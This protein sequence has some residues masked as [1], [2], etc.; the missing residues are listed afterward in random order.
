M[1]AVDACRDCQVW[2]AAQAVLEVCDLCLALH[3]KGVRDMG[4]L[5]NGG[6]WG[7]LPLSMSFVCGQLD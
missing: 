7:M 6:E 1:T 3:R 5:V 4:W 2:V